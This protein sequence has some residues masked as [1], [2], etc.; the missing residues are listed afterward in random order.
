MR[1]V[2]IMSDVKLP[3]VGNVPKPALIAVGAASV[4]ILAYA[5]YRRNSNATAATDTGTGTAVDPSIDPA[6][7]I[8]YADEYGYMNTGYSYQGVTDP[9]T[10]QII[11]SGVGT[12]VVTQ[13]TTNASWAQAAQA[14]LVTY[15]G[16]QDAS[17]VAA[18]LGSGLLGHYMTPDQLAI[19]NSAVA[20]EGD[21]PQGHPPINTTPPVGNPPAS[22]LPAAPSGFKI[23]K[24]TASTVSMSWNAVTGAKGYYVKVTGGGLNHTQLATGTSAGI[25]SLHKNT[26]YTFW[27]TAFNA[28]GNGPASNHLTVKTKSK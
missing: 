11:G 17:A 2:I 15:G 19:W 5:Y 6:T 3:G 18:A 9:T 26:S 20:F 14:Y 1:T 21:P 13:A 24:S 23:T 7:G 25:S 27:I 22:T 4:G 8:P 16:F 10:G 12:G 28:A